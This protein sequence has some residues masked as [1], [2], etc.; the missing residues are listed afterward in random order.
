MIN[1]NESKIKN[2]NKHL[3]TVWRAVKWTILDSPLEEHNHIENDL[4]L[5]FVSLEININL[6][7]LTPNISISCEKHID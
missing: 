6:K 1:D 5:F 2:C 7:T 4:S 3:F